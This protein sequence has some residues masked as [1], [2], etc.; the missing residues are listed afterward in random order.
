MIVYM[1]MH[2]VHS[3]NTFAGFGEQNLLGEANIAA[4][5]S[6]PVPCCLQ[7]G[8]VARTL[9]KLLG[10]FAGLCHHR[11]AVFAGWSSGKKG[12]QSSEEERER[13]NGTGER[14]RSRP[15]A[16]ARGSP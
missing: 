11:K 2:V 6:V 10:I 8:N 16:S 9:K 3:S 7:T 12:H 15:S 14:S 1:H 5:Y 4:C 13:G